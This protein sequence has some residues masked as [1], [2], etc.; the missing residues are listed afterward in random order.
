LKKTISIV[1]AILLVISGISLFS[2]KT[3]AADGDSD[4]VSVTGDIAISVESGKKLYDFSTSGGKIN[5][6]FGEDA[7]VSTSGIETGKRYLGY[8]IDPNKTVQSKYS[9]TNKDSAFVNFDGDLKFDNPVTVT[10]SVPVNAENV[11]VYQLKDGSTNELEE[12]VDTKKG[13]ADSNEYVSFTTDKLSKTYV[14]TGKVLNVKKVGEVEPEP[15]PEP[16]EVP[17]PQTGDNTLLYAGII[18][19]LVAVAF[20]MVYMRIKKQKEN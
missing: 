18:S 10:L 7:T 9:L 11:R 2:T 17:S 3:F 16:P 5:I 14:I 13:N 6:Y 12:I 4:A 15:V 19:I 8:N 20:L 1:L